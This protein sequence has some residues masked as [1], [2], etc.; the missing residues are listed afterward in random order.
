MPF[1]PGSGGYNA[2]RALLT[3]KLR[4]LEDRVEL[5]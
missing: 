5:V 1:I 4:F 3:A 2:F